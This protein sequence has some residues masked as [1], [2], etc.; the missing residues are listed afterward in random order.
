MDF[1]P[2]VIEMEGNGES[3]HLLYGRS[4][5]TKVWMSGLEK[6]SVELEVPSNKDPRRRENEVALKNRTG[7]TEEG[8]RGRSHI[9]S[10]LEVLDDEV[11]AGVVVVM[12]EAVATLTLRKGA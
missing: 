9:T 12:E 1:S 5:G 4:D 3:L 7:T 8:E 6:K 2:Q 10:R 11:E